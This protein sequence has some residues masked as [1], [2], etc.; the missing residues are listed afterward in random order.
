MSASFQ[1]LSINRGLECCVRSQPFLI[2]VNHHL[3]GFDIQLQNTEGSGHE[4]LMRKSSLRLLSLVINL[5]GTKVSTDKV[6][7]AD[8]LVRDERVEE[9]KNGFVSAPVGTIGELKGL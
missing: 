3:F 2:L 1:V 8:M 7:F 9:I 5:K 4:I 6:A